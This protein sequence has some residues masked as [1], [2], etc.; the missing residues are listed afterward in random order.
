MLDHATREPVTDASYDYEPGRSLAPQPPIRHQPD[1][2]DRVVATTGR[3]AA[4]PMVLG[5]MFVFAHA[6]LPSALDPFRAAGDA[7]GT[8]EAASEARRIPVAAAMAGQVALENSRV[9]SLQN[10]TVGDQTAAMIGSM[11]CYLGMLFDGRGPN[12]STRDALQQGCTIAQAAQTNI[13]NAYDR[14]SARNPYSRGY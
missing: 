9:Q 3:A 2:F 8:M 13:Q 14:Q 6:V 12:A 4:I 1:L 5:M 7:I 10:S 11:A